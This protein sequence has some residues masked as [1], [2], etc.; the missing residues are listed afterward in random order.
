[1]RWRLHGPPT[2]AGLVQVSA[3]GGV[4]LLLLLFGIAAR[5]SASSFGCVA[6]TTARWWTVC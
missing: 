3:V 1:M 2:I 5:S 4:S 6:P